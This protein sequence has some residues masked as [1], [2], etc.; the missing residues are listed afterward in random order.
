MKTRR[1]WDL[2]TDRG[3]HVVLPCSPWLYRYIYAINR[4]AVY[5]EHTVYWVTIREA[6]RLLLITRTE[7]SSAQGYKFVQSV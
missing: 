7:K 3:E 4:Y 6:K 2:I 5:V 1:N